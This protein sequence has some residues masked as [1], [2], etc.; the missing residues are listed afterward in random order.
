MMEIEESW[1]DD[2]YD[3]IEDDEYDDD[4]EYEDDFET[5]TVPCPAC[6]ADVYEEAQQ[7]PECGQY[8]DAA[9]YRS[10]SAYVWQDRPTWW[11]I[12]GIV[13]ILAVILGFILQ[14]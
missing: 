6:G 13:G 12:A 4:E 7:C 3:Y 8:I 14:F 5:E 11:I 10:G 9:D 2:D 1:D